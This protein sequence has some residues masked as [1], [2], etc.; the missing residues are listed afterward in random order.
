M[1]RRLVATFSHCSAKRL[2]P[3]IIRYNST[4]VRDPVANQFPSMIPKRPVMCD[5]PVAGIGIHIDH[6]AGMPV[7]FKVQTVTGGFSDN[8]SGKRTRATLPVRPCPYD[9]VDIADR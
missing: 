3:V 9:G 4:E 7:F 6:N 5:A 8:C 2:Q 1:R